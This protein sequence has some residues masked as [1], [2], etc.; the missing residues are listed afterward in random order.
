[1]GFVLVGVATL[2]LLCHRAM[3]PTYAAA[4]A[5]LKERCTEMS[6]KHGLDIQIVEDVVKL[7]Y[8]MNTGGRNFHGMDRLPRIV[9]AQHGP[10]FDTVVY[11][12]TLPTASAVE[13]EK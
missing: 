7:P 2:T 9:F 5:R 11:E 13:F 1:M 8:P 12:K 6:T 10:S 3:G 4:L